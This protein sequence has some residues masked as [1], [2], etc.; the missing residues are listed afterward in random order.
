MNFC[1]KGYSNIHV[2][3]IQHWYKILTIGNRITSWVLFGSYSRARTYFFLPY[4]RKG[5]RIEKRFVHVYQYCT[6]NR[7]RVYSWVLMWHFLSAQTLYSLPP[8]T[9][10]EG[11]RRKRFV[12]SKNRADT[13]LY[14]T[15]KEKQRRLK[16]HY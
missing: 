7:T 11:R 10:K 5:G 9:S 6:W 1:C 16:F 14:I 12:C 2:T 3:L 13:K 8:Y 4:L 15:M